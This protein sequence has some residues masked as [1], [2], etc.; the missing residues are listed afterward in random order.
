MVNEGMYRKMGTS[1][2]MG[3]HKRVVRWASAGK[4]QVRKRGSMKHSCQANANADALA[5]RNLARKGCKM[6]NINVY[7][8]IPCDFELN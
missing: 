3:V 1:E 7:F 2:I 6:D 5:G 4:A 8:I